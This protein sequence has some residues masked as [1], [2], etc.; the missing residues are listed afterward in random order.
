MRGALYFLAAA[1]VAV[2][3]FW[4]YRVNYDAKEALARI[5]RLHRQI[6]IEREALVVL[7]AEWAFLNAP[8]R[9]ADLA[10]RHAEALGLVP[11]DGARFAV[12]DT[13][14]LQEAFW[15][16]ADARLLARWHAVALGGLPSGDVPR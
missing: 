11:M 15:A 13:V 10:D 3:A 16:R 1:V 12:L 5:Q 9:L 6:A 7:Q 14:P 4:T 2:A 8:H